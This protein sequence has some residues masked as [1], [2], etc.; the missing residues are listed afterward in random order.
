MDANSPSKRFF[1]Y[2]GLYKVADWEYITGM[3]G[4]NVYKFKLVREANQNPFFR[5]DAFFRIIG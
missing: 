5:D 2:D 4:F 1:S 3:A